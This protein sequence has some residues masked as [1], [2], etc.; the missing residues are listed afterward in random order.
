MK[1]NKGHVE[2]LAEVVDGNV[3]KTGGHQSGVSTVERPGE[4]ARDVTVPM[5]ALHQ[6]FLVALGRPDSS[7]PRA[8]RRQYHLTS[9]G[10]RQV[11]ETVR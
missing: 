3:W 7:N 1:L 6:A 2:L 5:G 9:A 8:A 4:R 10:A 11:A